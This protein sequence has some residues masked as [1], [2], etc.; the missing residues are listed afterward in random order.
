MKG[1]ELIFL[2]QNW[3]CTKRKAYLREPP[4]IICTS[5]NAKMD[6]VLFIGLQMSS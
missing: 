5:N 1:N 4:T 6:E 3:I 2:K